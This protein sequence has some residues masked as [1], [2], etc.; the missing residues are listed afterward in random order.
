MESQ[1]VRRSR[2]ISSGPE[3]VFVALWALVFATYVVVMVQLEPA[4]WTSGLGV[5][6]LAGLAVLAIAF[7]IGAK[8]VRTV[9]PRH[10]K[11]LE[12]LAALWGAVGCSLAV[13]HLGGE[14]GLNGLGVALTALVVAAPLLM[15]AVWLWAR[16]R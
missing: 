16:G 11:I 2:S 5:W 9:R 13:I 7:G 8:R 1:E 10:Y 12:G 6:F 15:C 4:P 14:P 3:A